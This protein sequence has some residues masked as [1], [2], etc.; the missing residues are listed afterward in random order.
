MPEE[1]LCPVAGGE[2]IDVGQGVIVRPLPGL[3]CLMPFE[4]E[5]LHQ[6]QTYLGPR[7]DADNCDN[8]H[9]HPDGAVPD[10]LST[11]YKYVGKEG[12]SPMDI[13]EKMTKGWNAKALRHCNTLTIPIPSGL[14]GIRHVPDE[15]LPSDD[16]RAFKAYM[17]KN[18]GRFSL[19]DGGCMMYLVS[20]P[21]TAPCRC[22]LARH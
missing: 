19:W 16:F 8:L 6:S 14:G 18:W 21:S 7:G 4:R 9:C 3:H 13:T 15:K 22:P 10:V 12:Q 17:S 20:F 2:Y 5:C 11:D 1:Q